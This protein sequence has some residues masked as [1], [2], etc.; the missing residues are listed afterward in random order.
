MVPYRIYFR[1]QSGSIVGREDFHAESDGAATLLA[2]LLGEACSDMC[3]SFEVWHGTR[4]VAAPFTVLA[5]RQA[6]ARQITAKMQESI[7]RHEESIQKS[8]WAIAR[9]RRL[10]ERMQKVEA[11][12]RKLR[13]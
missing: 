5:P 11:E 8:K 7:L 6:S 10:L 12:L 3:D 1:S 13:V 9:S 4:R 2:G